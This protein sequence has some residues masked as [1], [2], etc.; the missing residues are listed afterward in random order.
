MTK[1]PKSLL[2]VTLAMLLSPAAEA[3]G[4]LDVYRQAL[5]SDPD[6]RAAGSSRLAALEVKPQAR[7]LLLPQV[8]ATLRQSHD[9]GVDSA[10]TPSSF[11][12]HNYDISISQP[13][14][15]QE[16]LVRQRQAEHQVTQAEADYANVQQDLVLRVAINYFA[17]LAAQDNLTFATAEKEAI[18][19][20]LEQAKRRFEVGLA[21]ITD[22]QEAQAGYD[23]AVSQE[24]DA[25][26]L[27]ADA[28]EALRQLTGQRYERINVL[29]KEIPLELPRPTDPEAWVGM[30][31]EK[32]LD[33]ASAS[34]SVEVA[35]EEI[36]R[37]KAGHYP[38]VDLVASHYD[39]DSGVSAG[40][41][42]GNTIGIQVS[43]PLYQ[44]G[45]VLSRTREAA[46]NYEAS[47]ERLESLQRTTTR[48]VRN[49]Y[50][51]VETG[52][53]QVKALKQAVI[54]SRSSLEATQAGY[55]VG[56]RTIVDVL[57]AQRTLYQTERD[58]ERSRYDYLINRLRLFQAA[59][60]LDEQ[61]LQ[62]I[63][64]YLQKPAN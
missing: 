27:L 17:V 64:R 23:R 43:I 10:R 29:K 36:N 3:V 5:D 41:A 59:G 9:F 14:F 57:L 46:Y 35:R 47:K 44:G 21:T 55:E 16:S 30:A 11:D 54:S 20:Q 62:E 40:D 38:S 53:S 49:A 18:A 39:T 61:D 26:Q 8:S 28:Y 4:L 31:L 22:V 1:L 34:A 19:R 32:N 15:R 50:R 45:A 48:Q 7:A 60:Q 51:G 63:D 56:T 33:I 25:R 52:I 37:Q 6:L 12:S 24:I 58:Y 2:A 42:D 13:L